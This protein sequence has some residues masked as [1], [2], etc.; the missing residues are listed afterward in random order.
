M[1]HHQQARIQIEQEILQRVQ[2]GNVQVVRRFVQHQYVRVLHQHGAQMQPAPF[3]SAQR[4]HVLV[5]LFLV[6]EKA[7]QQLRSGE[8]A[9]FRQ[10]DHVRDVAHDFQD[11][12][13]LLQLQ[14]LLTEIAEHDRFA[15]RDLAHVRL[16]ALG[17]QIDEGAFPDPVRTHDPDPV[18][19][20][21]RIVEVLHDQPV[22]EAFRQVPGFDHLS[23]QA[24]GVHLDRHLVPIEIPCRLFLDRVEGLQ[25]ALALRS[26][27]ARHLAHPFQLTFHQPA[28]VMLCGIAHLVQQRLLLHIVAVVALETR[29]AAEFHLDDLV[30]HVVQE[31][32]VVCHQ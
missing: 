12:L 13:V 30:A 20:L 21:Q 18:A 10:R 2:R 7:L 15:D 4:A 27:G 17:E 31:I 23:A 28:Q 14:A 25:P 9:A 22:A 16:L 6:E 19:A 24:R 32:P 26:A 8:R 1:A 11:A 5:L 3:A 29:E